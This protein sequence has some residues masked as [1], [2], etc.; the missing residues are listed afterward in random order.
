MA[1]QDFI[2]KIKHSL[3]YLTTTILVGLCFFSL[4]FFHDFKVLVGLL[5]F[6]LVLS[7]LADFQRYR[8]YQRIVDQNRQLH[9]VEQ[10]TQAMR[11]SM[12][13]TEVLQLVVHNL[14]QEMHYKRVIL[15]IY[16][17]EK[18]G[19]DYIKPMVSAG[20]DF[21]VVKNYTFRID[22]RLDIL[23]RA[24]VERKPF[25]VY[26]ASE[27]YRCDQKFV[28]LLMLKRYVVV[29]FIIKEQPLGVL[30]A[31]RQEGFSEGAI[32]EDELPILSV[33]ANQAG[34]AIENA[35]LYN[36][37]EE[38]AVTDSLTNLNNRRFFAEAYLGE[39][40]RLDRYERHEQVLS[41]I[42]IDVDHFKNYNDTSGHQAGDQVLIELGQILKGT[43]RK[44]DVVARY[45]GEE[46][47]IMLPVT[48]KKKAMMLAERLRVAVESFPFEFGDKQPLGRVTIS[49]GVATFGEDGMT[50]K[51][52]IAAA[53][54][55]LYRAKQAGRNRICAQV[56]ENKNE[57]E[58]RVAAP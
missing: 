53:D 32:S 43:L 13:L 38:L 35:R 2:E 11:Q 18:K 31:D 1:D 47:I 3:N 34:M 14:E 55:Q 51:D 9:Y 54:E 19:Y 6:L 44:V 22:K 12:K 50:E 29:P 16:V 42:M 23:P 40:S 10:L 15:Y 25:I 48:D 20:I 33:F 56:I 17:Q 46:F 27:D 4:Y 28:A 21:E 5:T 41:L 49:A 45:G 7:L 26:N 30:L 57:R 39:L 58:E 8:D 37:I 24:V 52:L 36:Q